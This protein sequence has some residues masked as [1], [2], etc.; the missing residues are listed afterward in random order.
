MKVA[1]VSEH[2][3]PLAVLGG[4]DAGGQNVHVAAL[5]AALGRRGADVV[6]HTRRDDPSLP[7]RVPLDRGAVVDHVD[8]GPVREIPKDDLFDFMDEFAEDLVRCWSDERPDVVHAH[9]WMSAYAA[10]KAARRLGIPAA[11]IN[12][13]RE[14]ARGAERPD[15][16]HSD[17]EPGVHAG[18]PRP[19]DSTNPMNRSISGSAGRSSRARSMACPRLRSELKN[20]R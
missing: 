6:V 10:L 7:R 5:A 18:T 4:V 1:M 2:A 3:S 9:F 19:E 20:S 17:R 15:A 11:W 8:A 16:D 14:P 12:R 13:K